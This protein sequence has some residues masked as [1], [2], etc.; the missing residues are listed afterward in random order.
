MSPGTIETEI[1]RGRIPGELET[2]LDLSAKEVT[3][4]QRP[5][6]TKALELITCTNDELASVLSCALT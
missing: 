1:C 6:T 5:T 4:E 3:R 2:P